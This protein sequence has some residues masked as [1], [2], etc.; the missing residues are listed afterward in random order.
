VKSA[1]LAIFDRSLFVE[2]ATADRRRLL[3]EVWVNEN[4]SSVA[5]RFEIGAF[6]VPFHLTAGSGPCSVAPGK[7]FRTD[8]TCRGRG[9]RWPQTRPS[10]PR[11]SNDRGR[12]PPWRE[13]GGSSSSRCSLPWSLSSRRPRP[14]IQRG[15]AA[16]T[17]QRTATKSSRWSV[18]RRAVTGWRATR[19]ASLPRSRRHFTRW[20]RASRKASPSNSWLG[21]H[22]PA[23]AL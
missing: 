7:W 3:G 16:F 9:E 1:A 20:N 2:T 15:S 8:P 22:R 17:M 14:P 18:T 6:T 4:F 13:H 19:F 23:S 11:S 21:G 5:F 10:R 12:D